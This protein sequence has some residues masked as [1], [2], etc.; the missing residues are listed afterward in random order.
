[1]VASEKYTAKI[2]GLVV[3]SIL[4]NIGTIRI[5][6]NPR[7]AKILNEEEVEWLKRNVKEVTVTRVRVYVE[8]VEV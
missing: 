1:M 6:I 8:E 4:S 5:S 3:K 7:E 2:G